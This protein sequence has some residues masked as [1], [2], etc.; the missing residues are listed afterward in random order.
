MYLLFSFGAL[1]F[2]ERAMGGEVSGRL[3]IDATASALT[4]GAKGDDLPDY[5]P[6]RKMM[7]CEFSTAP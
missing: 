4:R 7:W 1:P 6:A 3:L 5:W 2:D